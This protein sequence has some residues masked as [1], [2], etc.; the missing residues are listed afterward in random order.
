MADET[1]PARPVRA[2][3]TPLAATISIVATLIGLI[4]LAWTILFVTKGRFLKHPFER[5]VSAQ[6]ARQVKVAG[7]F[8]LY[9]AP[10]NVRFVAEGMTVTNPAWVRGNF[11]E[12]KKVDSVISTWSL[13]TGNHR[14]NW[15]SLDDAH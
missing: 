12:A 4:V 6:T 13:I 14:I 9:F 7:D 8:Q 2:L 1:A 11:F 3:G 10:F 15:L 5:F